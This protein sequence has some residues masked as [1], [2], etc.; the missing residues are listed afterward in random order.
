MAF[1]HFLRAGSKKLRCGY[2][3]GT[4]A[5]LATAGAAELL[6][7]GCKPEK[8]SLLTPGGIRVNVEPE[9]CFM[10][11]DQA[12]CAVRK[13]A[14]DDPD[15]TDGM[16]IFALVEKQS[17][18]IT[19]DAG[20]GIGIVTRPGLD[21][22]VGAAAINSVPRQMIR[23]AAEAVC[24]EA[25]YAGGLHIVL[26]VPG[27]EELAGKTFNPQLGIEG[28]ISILGTSGIVRPMSEEA[29]V[30]TIALE[31][32]QTAASGERRLI[33]TPGNYGMDFLRAQMPWL[34]RVKSARCSN[35]VGEAMDIAAA[36][37]FGEILLV[38]HV[39]KYVKLA[40]GIMNTHSRMADCRRELFIAHAALCGADAGLCRRLMEQ[41]TTEGCLDVLEDAGLREPVCLSLLKEIQRVLSRRSPEGMIAGLLMFSNQYGLLGMTETAAA[42]LNGWRDGE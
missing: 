12:V 4:C 8:L 34:G 14:G 35:Y 27:G 9:E 24:E 13:D 20:A 36:E 42:L 17:T 28:G 6:L 32:R 7:T 5:A 10:K 22:P 25:E 19:L 3:T 33:L 41:V 31:I 30:D 23:A 1:E 16:L 2:T 11:G 15:V 21:Q 26:E 29:I 18:G 39:G 40:G 37:G 38:G